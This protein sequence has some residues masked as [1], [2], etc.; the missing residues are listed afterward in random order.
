M[1]IQ[2]N[3]NKVTIVSMATELLP[4]HEELGYELMEQPEFE[5]QGQKLKLVDGELVVD[6]EL[7]EELA[8]KVVAKEVKVEKK[9]Q[10]K[11]L[12]VTT[13]AGNE[14]QADDSSRSNMIEALKAA[15]VLGLEKSNWK[16]AD[17]TVV[18]V[19]VAEIE[20]ALALGIVA[21]GAIILAVDV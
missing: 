10:I 13:E 18:E 14:F 19:T 9:K 6:T 17:N 21:K 8:A 20:E 16:L 12:T 5:V 4:I 7:M 11:E 1:I 15:E 2:N 3:N